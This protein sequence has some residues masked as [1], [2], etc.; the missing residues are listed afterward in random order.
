MRLYNSEAWYADYRY[1]FVGVL[2]LFFPVSIL[3]VVFW[4]QM[5]CTVAIHLNVP[6]KEIYGFPYAWI[7]CLVLPIVGWTLLIVMLFYIV[8]WSIVMLACGEGEKYI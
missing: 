5:A 6:G 4:L 1:W 7:V 8:S 2:F 3:F